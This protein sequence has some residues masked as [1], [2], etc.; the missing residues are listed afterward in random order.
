MKKTL[1]ALSLCTII[2]VAFPC[3]GDDATGSGS[4]FL[5]GRALNMDG[6]SANFN[7]YNAIAPGLFT[8]GDV[9][10]DADRYHFTADGAYLGPDDMFIGLKGGKYGAYKYS[11]YF[12]EFPH[13][14]S[15]KDRTIYNAPGS[16][17]L[18]FN[19]PAP[20]IPADSSAWPST[21]FDY[22]VR[23]KDVGGT[24]DVTAVRPFFINFDVNRLNRE[25]QK[26]HGAPDAVGQTFGRMVEFPLAV[27]NT[28]TNLNG[29]AAWRSKRFY[30]AF[31]GGFSKFS[32]R[33]ESTRFRDP[34]TTGAAAATGTVVEEPDNK[35]WSLKFTGNSKLPCAS[36][37]V[38][39][40]GYT[41]NTSETTLLNTIEDGTAA[42]PIVKTLTLS[43][44]V[45][46]GDV[47]YWNIGAVLTSNPVRDLNT[48][49]YYKYLDRK[50]NSDII[51]FVDPST[52]NS[53][54][55]EIFDYQKTTFG[56]EGSYRFARNLK[57]I[58]GYEFS[59]LIR[60]AKETEAAENSEV[61][62]IRIPDT[63]DHRISAQLVYNP[64]DW[65]SGRL[66]YQKLYRGATFRFAPA[67]PSADF[68]AAL[69]N[70]LRRFYAANKRQDMVKLTADVSPLAG[71]DVALEYAYKRDNYYKTILGVNK[72]TG[73]EFVVDATYDWR[74][75]KLFGFF[76]Y[77]TSYWKQTQ[78][79]VTPLPGASA[80]PGSAPNANSYN[81]EARLDNINY[82]Y[83]FGATLPLI[84][85]KLS[86]TVQ[87][88]FQKN[89]GTADFTSQFLSTGLNQSN[90]DIASW[91]DY[92]Q[93]T[94]SA[95]LAY[96]MTKDLG[97][98]FGYLYSQFRWSDGQ[99]NGYTYVVGSPI[100]S[101]LTG[102]YTDQPYNANV[103][104]AKMTY[105]F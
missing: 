32:N 83:G 50:N 21:S 78:R 97:L 46:N 94:V 37:F 1:T 87:Y 60:R 22:K 58:L 68:N 49:V 38:V 47:E 103:F 93:Q 5:G 90:I 62:E 19:G 28:T 48:K 59:D 36:T 75:I 30:A 85:D 104:Y 54:S 23:R 77:D 10:Y 89:N 4:I 63:W 15:F 55:S 14:L 27:D 57:G 98:M 8:G 16:Q 29:L 33:A 13:N 95:R 6:Q 71:L 72:S 99:F 70:Y 96:E 86:F 7:Q 88:D 65:L 53:T 39:N 100:N 45:F 91:D 61:P 102:A 25:G 18:T 82:A 31:S 74:S 73:N 101:F 105:R 24:F 35:S 43:D 80:D 42:A 44:R 12:N 84:R 69:D 11:L 64:L 41:H 81:W 76:D 9:S 66:K 20:A 56:A 34:Y 51:T 52:G 17:D 3:Y 92:T 67:D 79:N 26:P 2:V 40:A